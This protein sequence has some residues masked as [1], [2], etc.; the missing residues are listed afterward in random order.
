M[1]GTEFV[2]IIVT[3]IC[4]TS[5]IKAWINKQ[6]SRIDEESLSRLAQ[7]FKKHIKEMQRRIRNLEAIVAD[8]EEDDGN[9]FHQIETEERKDTLNNDL[10]QTD[11]VRS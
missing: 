4:A 6:H 3:I 8:A 7:V 1:D 2:V 11:K 10:Q 5:L 9:H